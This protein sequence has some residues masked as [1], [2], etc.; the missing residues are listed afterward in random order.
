MGS[1]RTFLGGMVLMIGTIFL[2]VFAQSM[3]MLMA[4][5]FMMGIPWGMFRQSNVSLAADPFRGS[6][7]ALS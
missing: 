1:R 6:G 5:E 3:S 7:A 4:A 2:A